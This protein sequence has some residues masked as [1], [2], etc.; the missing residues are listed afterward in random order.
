VGALIGTYYGAV[1]VFF[2]NYASATLMVRRGGNK[3]DILTPAWG[4]AA[5]TAAPCIITTSPCLAVYHDQNQLPN[6]HYQHELIG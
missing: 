6:E 3:H 5:Q 4:Q 2:K 1:N